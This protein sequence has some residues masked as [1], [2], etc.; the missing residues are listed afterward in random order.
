MSRVD[1]NARGGSPVGPTPAAGGAP[2]ADDPVAGSRPTRSGSPARSSDGLDLLR[3]LVPELDELVTTVKT[4]LSNLN[5]LATGSSPPPSPAPTTTKPPPVPPPAT[6]PTSSQIGRNRDGIGVTTTTQP[7]TSHSPW[8]VNRYAPKNKDGKSTHYRALVNA[9]KE[10]AKAVGA[11]KQAQQV[12]EKAERQHAAAPSPRTAA[13]V[14]A[15]EKKLASATTARSVAEQKVETAQEKLRGVMKKQ[16]PDKAAEIDALDLGAHQVTR[17]RFAVKVG[18]TTVELHNAI[19]AYGTVSSKGLEG[20]AK[21]DSRANVD[22]AISCSGLTGS[23]PTVLKATSVNEGNFSTI[24]G[25]DHKGITFGFIQMAGGQ[26]GDV[27]PTMLATFKKEHPQEFAEMLGN[28]GIDVRRTTGG[29]ELVVR[30]PDGSVLTGADAARAIGTDPK[31]AGALAA[32]GLNSDMQDLQVRV[33][34]GILQRQREEEIDVNGQKVKISDLITSE[35]GNGILFDRSVHEGSGGAR[36]TLD[37]VAT[38][39]LETHKGAKLSDESVR[40][41]IEA[42][43]ITE[44][45]GNPDFAAR[46]KNIADRT[47][48]E[49]GSYVE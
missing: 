19:E 30:Q 31:L 8:D 21:G 43:Y 42:A 11:E 49:R 45:S 5:R 15:A 27:L 22:S 41:A 7:T 9:D 2:P 25:W 37:R 12:L 3:S 48:V 6:G 4:G 44:I 38:E 36:K 16:S 14:E 23:A 1:P 24:N 32:T 33:A 47:S 10:L 13:A 34:N 17:E 39:Y 26:A 20:Q 28:Y 18:D 29:S 46:C 35:T 40:A